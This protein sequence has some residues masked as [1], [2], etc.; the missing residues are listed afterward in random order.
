LIIWRP[1]DDEQT[2]EYVCAP[3]VSLSATR[4]R[5]KRRLSNDEERS[6]GGGRVTSRGRQRVVEPG[7][8]LM[9]RIHF[10]RRAG[11]RPTEIVEPVETI[12]A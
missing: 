3:L 2:Q 4:Q 11:V 8:G 6:R 1:V 9:E 7:G 10:D 12:A 5:S